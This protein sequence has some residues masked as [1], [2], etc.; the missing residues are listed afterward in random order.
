VREGR[1]W[2]LERHAARL[3]HDA[4]IAGV[5]ALDPQQCR[6]A[7][8]AAARAHF[9]HGEGIVRLE[10]HAGERGPALVVAPRALGPEPAHWR[11]TTA[12]EPHPGPRVAAG[13]KW[14]DDPF[15]SRARQAARAAGAD[16]VLLFDADGRL[17]EGARTSLV[18]VLAG[19]E[20]RTP[21]LARG[22]VAGVAR[23]VALAAL[24][25]L[26]EA[27]VTRA[28]LAGA[29]ELVALNAVRGA[30]AITRLDGAAVGAGEPGPWARRLAR[31]L[32][33]ADGP[34]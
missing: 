2:L 33:A 31:A 23:A 18:V 29:R 16:D 9:A 17:V 20:A 21:P 26:A 22:G 13:V 34:L 24:P 14:V 32:E 12:A 11:A 19:G 3:A 15:L 27:D 28:A 30:R 25:E 10:A 5:G 7:L 8:E 6:E 1:V 4:R